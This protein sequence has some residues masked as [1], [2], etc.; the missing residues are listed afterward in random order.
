MA[1]AA[2]IE[3]RLEAT[4][5][6]LQSMLC[7]V[8]AD[9]LMFRSAVTALREDGVL[10]EKAVERIGEDMQRRLANYDNPA[11]TVR[12]TSEIG[13]QL[14]RLWERLRGTTKGRSRTDAS[15]PSPVL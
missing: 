15:E 13:F 14:R 12:I 9:L 3:K 10:T 2:E 4:E 8:T 11:L 6:I 5:A 7:T 1:S